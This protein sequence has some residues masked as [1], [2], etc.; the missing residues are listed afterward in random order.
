[1]FSRLK[2][3]EVLEALQRELSRISNR[4]RALTQWSRGSYIDTTQQRLRQ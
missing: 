2:A 3:D 4:V 1:M